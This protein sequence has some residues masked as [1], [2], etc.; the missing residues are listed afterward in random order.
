MYIAFICVILL[1]GYPD[2]L[3]SSSEY[4]A[5]SNYAMLFE[6][7][8]L[9][10]S[11]QE[12]GVNQEIEGV[13][14]ATIYVSLLYEYLAGNQCPYQFEVKTFIWNII[15]RRHEEVVCFEWSALSSMLRCTINSTPHLIKI[16]HKTDP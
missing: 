13:R 15:F 16:D 1:F 9:A 2:V 14:N 12:L 8:N 6:K 11:L 4:H 7:T 5:K 3:A 10:Q